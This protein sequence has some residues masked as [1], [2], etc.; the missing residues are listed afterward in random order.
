M[1]LTAV[2]TSFLPA[3][4]F[5]K[6]TRVTF[7]WRFL[8]PTFSQPSSVTWKE[9]DYS[10]LHIYHIILDITTIAIADVTYNVLVL[11]NCTL[12]SLFQGFQ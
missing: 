5:L 11:N 4:M 8:A 1:L 6:V 3:E 7:G 12:I 10:N 9:K 2:V